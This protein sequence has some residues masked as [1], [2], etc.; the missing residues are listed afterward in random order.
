MRTRLLASV[1]VLVHG[2]T[3]ETFGFLLVE[4]EAI[5]QAIERLF[6][7]PLADLGQ[8]ARARARRLPS[9]EDHFRAL[10]ELYAARLAVRSPRA[11]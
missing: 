7:R 11:E 8:R 4:P 9:T 1:D 3:C 5:A 6:A 2:S 10:F